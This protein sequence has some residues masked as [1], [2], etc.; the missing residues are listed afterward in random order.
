MESVGCSGGREKITLFCKHG[1]FGRMGVWTAGVRRRMDMAS[2][3]LL[4]QHNGTRWWKSTGQ[5]LKMS[6]TFMRCSTALLL[7]S[8]V[9]SEMILVRSK[10]CKNGHP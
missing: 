7:L 8:T 5:R 3:L 1:A 4:R 10:P 9:I 6:N 2:F